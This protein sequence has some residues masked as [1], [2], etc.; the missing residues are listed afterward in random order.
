MSVEP[1][2]LSSMVEEVVRIAVSAGQEILKIYDERYQ[3][4]HKD[5]GSPVTTADVRAHELICAE[6]SAMT[7][8]IP[9]LSEEAPHVSVS[10]RQQWSHFWLID[11]LD[12][13]KEFIQ[14]NG[15]FTVNIAL[16]EGTRPV[17]GVVHTPVQSLTHFGSRGAGAYRAVGD[18]PA[19]QISSCRYDGAQVRMV[20]SRS[21]S[22]APV[23]AFR[24]ALALES[25]APVD[26]VNMG[27]ALKVC[28]VAEGQANVYP[29]L[30]PTSEWDTAAAHSV[31]SEAGG[32]IVDLD[33]NALRYNK[34]DLLNPWFIAFGDVDY[35]W[36]GL[37]RRAGVRQID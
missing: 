15:E 37:A 21:H 29:R 11:P 10:E 16:I 25:G 28:L 7:P 20:A 24:D 4:D 32:G 26:V 6:L 19:E 36:P 3:I 14:R 12:G 34:T 23:V 13:T 18:A 33:G 1:L 22:G 2:K 8:E 31:L 9:L 27:S 35:D 30:G 5:D 17:L